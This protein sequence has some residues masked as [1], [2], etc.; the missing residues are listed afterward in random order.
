MIGLSLGVVRQNKVNTDLVVIQMLGGQ[1]TCASHWLRIVGAKRRRTEASSTRVLTVATGDAAARAAV[2]R[3]R[4]AA[5]RWERL[6]TVKWDAMGQE[7]FLETL[8][9]ID[10]GVTIGDARSIKFLEAKYFVFESLDVH[11]LAFSMCSENG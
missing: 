7:K 11:L 2:V 3:G 9:L 8:V 10:N 5:H 6:Q 1:L 4:H